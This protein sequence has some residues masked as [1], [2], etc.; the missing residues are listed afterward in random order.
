MCLVRCQGGG[1]QQP[2]QQTGDGSFQL[3]HGTTPMGSTAAHLGILLQPDGRQGEFARRMA[4][5]L[6]TL[7]Q[8]QRGMSSQWGVRLDSP[9]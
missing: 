9:P 5:A 8:L 1:V 3:A 2:Q 7:A 4:K 6:G